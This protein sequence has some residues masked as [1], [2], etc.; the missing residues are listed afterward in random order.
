MRD[1]FAVR[2]TARADSLRA[3]VERAG[4]SPDPAQLIGVV[5]PLVEA[6]RRD[7]DSV[8]QTIREVLTA[9]QWEK[10]PPRLRDP[11]QRPRRQP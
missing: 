3:A 11:P 5:R 2:N 10:L 8:L 6:G 4:P 7:G 1:S 9:E